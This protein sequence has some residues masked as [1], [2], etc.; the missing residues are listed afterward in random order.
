[1]EFI[2]TRCFEQDKKGIIELGEVSQ[3]LEFVS[4]TK[5]ASRDM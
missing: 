3:S 5:L 4:V 1:M 2:I